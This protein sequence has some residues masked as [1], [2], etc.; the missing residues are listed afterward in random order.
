[1][2]GD[3]R[4]GPGPPDP[5]GSAVW[6][7]RSRPAPGPRPGRP[8]RAGRGGPSAAGA[9]PRPAPGPAGLL[10]SAMSCSS[11]PAA[12]RRARSFAQGSAGPG[13]IGRARGRPARDRTRGRASRPRADPPPGL[14]DPGDCRRR[15]APHRPAR[16]AP[17]P[18]PAPRRRRQC[19]VTARDARRHFRLPGGRGASGGVL[20]HGRSVPRGAGGGRGLSHFPRHPHAPAPPPF[21]SWPRGERGALPRGGRSLPFPRGPCPP[22]RRPPSRGS[23]IYFVPHLGR[24]AHNLD[25]V[26]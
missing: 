15:P 10:T 26:A 5:G 19:D 22:P 12:P 20:G 4:A 9:G 13:H 17:P 25:Q 11:R 7:G 2:N 24:S 23:F 16:V 8:L 6:A 1:M 18:R 21:R 14:G 3:P